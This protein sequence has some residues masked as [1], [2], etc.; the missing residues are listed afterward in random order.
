M[1]YTGEKRQTTDTIMNIFRGG[2]SILHPL[3]REYCSIK[4]VIK[5]KRGLSHVK[6]FIT[7]L[8]TP[9]KGLEDEIP[10]RQND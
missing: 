3:K 2:K 8:T 5:N 1:K 9:I 10:G 4:Y 7:I 6:H